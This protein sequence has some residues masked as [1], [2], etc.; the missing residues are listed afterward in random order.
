[1][2]LAVHMLLHCALVAVLAPLVIL[3]RPLNRVLATASPA[4]RRR[5]MAALR[6]RPVRVLTTPALAWT[7]FVSTQV[8]FHVT[9][10][11][12][13]N[14]PVV[15][16]IGHTLFLA[17]ALL[18]WEVAIGAAPLPHRLSGLAPALYLISAMPAVD[19]SAAW[20]M[21]QGHPA[22]GAAMV[23]GMT[24]IGLAAAT[25]AWLAARDEEARARLERTA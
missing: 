16:G 6:S 21:A 20:L 22:A 14:D 13:V 5:L 4:R 9:G 8:A 3:A 11:Y 7:L 2:S 17:T 15:D 18:F 24:P 12:A 10:L 1:M 19:L 25:S 23:A